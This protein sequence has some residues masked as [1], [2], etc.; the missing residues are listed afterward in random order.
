MPQNKAMLAVFQNSGLPVKM[1]F[2]GDA[3]TIAI[4]LLKKPAIP[5]E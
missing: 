4:D 2:D 3:Y 5:T 1:E